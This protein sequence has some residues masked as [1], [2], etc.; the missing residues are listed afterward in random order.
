MRFLAF[1]S[2]FFAV[3]Q[4]AFA[5]SADDLRESVLG[6]FRQFNNDPTLAGDPAV[7]SQPRRPPKLAVHHVDQVDPATTEH[8]TTMHTIITKNGDLHV[9]QQTDINHPDGSQ[10]SQVD[11][12]TMNTDGKKQ[13]FHGEIITD[14]KGVKTLH[15]LNHLATVQGGKQISH[16]LGPR[17]AP[18]PKRQ[19]QGTNRKT[20]RQGRRPRTGLQ[21]PSPTSLWKPP[22]NGLPKSP[23]TS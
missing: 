7:S 3:T 2:V 23:Q 6:G 4:V 12:K 14:P 11:H 21:K 8:P 17:P 22:P 9:V 5:L 16:G 19:P 20:R 13:S 18:N 1:V 15:I 10:T